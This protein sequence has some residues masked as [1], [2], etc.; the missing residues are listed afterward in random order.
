MRQRQGWAALFTVAAAGYGS[1]PGAATGAGAG[2]RALQSGVEGG[3]Y[4]ELLNK[5]EN[6]YDERVQVMPPAQVRGRRRC[7]SPLRRSC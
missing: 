4:F 5:N 1:H 6:G 7:A 2:R 3:T